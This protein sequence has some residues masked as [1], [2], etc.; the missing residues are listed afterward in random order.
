[1]DDVK[2]IDFHGFTYEFD[3][4][5]TLWVELGGLKIGVV[6]TFYCMDRGRYQF[7]PEVYSKFRHKIS[8]D[9]ADS[10]P[11]YFF[12]LQRAIDEMNDWVS[13]RAQLDEENKKLWELKEKYKKE[14]EDKIYSETKKDIADSI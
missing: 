10:F 8:V 14:E 12:S 5:N 13:F 2:S 6:K 11:R 7:Y 9:Q 3:D 4:Y 1:M